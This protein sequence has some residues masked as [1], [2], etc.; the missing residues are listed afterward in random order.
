MVRSVLEGR[1]IGPVA[2]NQL[3]IQPRAGQTPLALHSSRGDLQHLGSFLDAQSTEEFQFDYFTLSPIM[4]GK[5]VQRVVDRN[6]ICRRPCVSDGGFV[7]LNRQCLASTLARTMTTGMIDQR[8]PHQPCRETKEVRAILPG[9]VSPV[10]QTEVYL[11]DQG[12]GLECVPRPLSPHVPSGQPT[13]LGV[14]ERD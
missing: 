8:A 2:L 3:T 11:V 4:L 7:E 12:G 9:H 14:D 1:S 10:D 5:G 6:Q 13:Q